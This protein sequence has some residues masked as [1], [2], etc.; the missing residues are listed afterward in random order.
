M[1]SFRP[2]PIAALP[3]GSSIGRF[4]CRLGYF[5]E[6]SDRL[7][8][9]L[10]RS[11][12]ICRNRSTNRAGETKAAFSRSFSESPSC[13]ILRFLSGRENSSSVTRISSRLIFPPCLATWQRTFFIACKPVRSLVLAVPRGAFVERA[14]SVQVSPSKYASVI[15]SR[16]GSGRPDRADESVRE[17]SPFPRWKAQNQPATLPLRLGKIVHS[18]SFVDEIERDCE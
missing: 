13:W 3:R 14:I 12:A 18:F 11:S 6:S 4:F 7:C 5:L 10:Q 9:A 15:A 2:Q 16:C 1:A 8:Q 17:Q